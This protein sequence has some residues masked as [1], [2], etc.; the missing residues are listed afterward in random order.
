MQPHLLQLSQ[1]CKV[2]TSMG[3]SAGIGDL[4]VMGISAQKV[5]IFNEYLGL[6]FNNFLVER[7]FFIGINLV[8]DF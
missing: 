2:I 6:R 4:Y 3:I 8:V 7:F 5:R 1:E